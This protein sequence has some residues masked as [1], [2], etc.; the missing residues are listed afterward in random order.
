[1]NRPRRG[2]PM[3]KPTPPAYRRRAEN[4]VLVAAWDLRETANIL[5]TSRAAEAVKASRWLHKL[6]DGLFVAAGY[7]EDAMAGKAKPKRKPGVKR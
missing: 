1:M 5:G 6:A 4:A 3:S 7:P 2:G